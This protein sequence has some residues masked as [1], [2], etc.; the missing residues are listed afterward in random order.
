[1]C[2]SAASLLPLIF[3]VLALPG[4]VWKQ[5]TGE[6]VSWSKDFPAVDSVLVSHW[7]VYLGVT[8]ETWGADFYLAFVCMAYGFGY[9]HGRAAGFILFSKTASGE[10]EGVCK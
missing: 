8:I 5:L 7:D 2:C 3:K 9:W 6:E 4:F 10:V 1:M